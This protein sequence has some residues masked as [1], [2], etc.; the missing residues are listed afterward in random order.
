MVKEIYSL[1]GYCFYSAKDLADFK[2]QFPD[3]W[4]LMKD[5]PLRLSGLSMSS[6][7]DFPD[8]LDSLE[9][10]PDICLA[11]RA[12]NARGHGLYTSLWINGLEVRGIFGYYESDLIS[13]LVDEID[14]F[15][16]QSKWAGM[17]IRTNLCR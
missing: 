17:K 6:Y 4:E 15:I 9:N 7:D 12:D 3:E 16:S 14:Q 11:Y 2:I 10:M 5:S 8:Y 13:E 1:G